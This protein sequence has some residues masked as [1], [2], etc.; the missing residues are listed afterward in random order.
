MDEI[1][2]K[3]RQRERE[4]EER[5]RLRRE[6]I[7]GGQPTNGRPE[8]PAVGSG[9]TSE[10]GIAVAAA[11]SPG[12]YV[13]KFKQRLEPSGHS[14]PPDAAADKWGSSGHR[15]SHTPPGDRWRSSFGGGSRST[16]SSWSSSRR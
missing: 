15:P 9:H 2:E 10:T 8:L 11:P 1:A 4:L 7:L 14:P 6:A 16:T 13:P 3:Q 12:K 5:E